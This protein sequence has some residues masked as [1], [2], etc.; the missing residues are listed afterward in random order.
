MTTVGISGTTGRMSTLSRSALVAALLS[1]VQ[2]ASAVA[3]FSFD[4]RTVGHPLAGRFGTAM[5][6]I[7][8]AARSVAAGDATASEEALR[9]IL[10]SLLQIEALANDA[11][12]LPGPCLGDPA[13]V[14]QCARDTGPL[15]AR[16][17][18]IAQTMQV[19]HAADTQSVVRVLSVSASAVARLTPLV[20][21]R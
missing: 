17:T 18:Q 21:R 5:T 1:A 9:R 3:Q 11:R 8:A 6:A 14:F 7:A 10:Q 15:L 13:A 16:L 19:L 12:S 2:A 20:T 4:A